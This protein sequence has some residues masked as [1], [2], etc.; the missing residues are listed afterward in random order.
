[1]VGILPSSWKSTTSPQQI[2]W[3]GVPR[4]CVAELLGSPLR[5]GMGR[6]PEVEDSAA[7]VSQNQEHIQELKPDRRHREEVDDTMVLT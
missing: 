3:R 5:G 6:D 1:M 2:T 7:L 4:K